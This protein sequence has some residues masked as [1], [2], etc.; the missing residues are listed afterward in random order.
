[1][2]AI[3]MGKELMS[4]C[5]KTILKN[6]LVDMIVATV[7][8]AAI[9]FFIRPTIVNGESMANTLHNGDYLIMARQAYSKH[10]PE[11]G[12]IVIIQSTLTDCESGKDKFIV[13]RKEIYRVSNE[14]VYTWAIMTRYQER[15]EDEYDSD[16]TAF[17][18]D[19]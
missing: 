5:K 16:K 7:L 8:A 13:K 6:M 10:D 19:Y 3:S 12:D 17:G 15:T 14:P 18:Y 11:K 9:L 4:N 1:M 2:K